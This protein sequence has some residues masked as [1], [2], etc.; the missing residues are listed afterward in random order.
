MKRAKRKKFPGRCLFRKFLSKCSVY[1]TSSPSNTN[2]WLGQ[3]LKV[4][5]SRLGL[6]RKQKLTLKY[7]KVFWNEVQN[8][9]RQDLNRHLFYEQQEPSFSSLVPKIASKTKVMMS[10]KIL[11]CLILGKDSYYTE[12]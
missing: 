2:K 10:N 1:L 4:I 5:N 12:T 3:E 8:E 7:C 11:S 6:K 9:T